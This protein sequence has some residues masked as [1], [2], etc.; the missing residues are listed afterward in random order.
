MTGR[1]G[2]PSWLLATCLG[3]GNRQMVK[4]KISLVTLAVRNVAAAKAFYE[5]LGWA[6]SSDHDEVAFFELDGVVLGLYGWDDLA[7]DAGVAT[8]DGSAFRG[9]SLAHNEPS[10]EDVDRVFHEF[11]DAGASVV[12]RPESTPWGGYSGYVA[13]LD[14]HLWEIA[15]NPF[16]DWT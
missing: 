15:F 11:I 12:K 4:P 2:V 10:P 14:G 5:R 7:N 8:S 3:F 6:C 9:H 13:D 1:Y 16:N